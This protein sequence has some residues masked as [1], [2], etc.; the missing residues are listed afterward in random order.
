M[1]VSLAAAGIQMT[2]LIVMLT[3]QPSPETVVILFVVAAFWGFADGL[4]IT[5]LISE[6]SF[7]FYF[8]HVVS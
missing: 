1:R 2:M 4:L 7:M 3:G 8:F 6:S 5:Q